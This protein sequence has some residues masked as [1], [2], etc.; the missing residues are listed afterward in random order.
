MVSATLAADGRTFTVRAPGLSGCQGGFSARIKVGDQEQELSSADGPPAASTKRV[1][2]ATPYGEAKLTATTIHFEQEQVD[3]LLR[4]GRVPGLPAVLAQVG[5][6]NTGQQPLDLLAVTPMALAVQVTGRPADWVI[7]GFKSSLQAVIGLDD[8]IKPLDVH[9]AG[10]LYNTEG[11]GFLFGPVGTPTSYVDARFT[12]DRGEGHVVFHM[13][14]DMSGACVEPGET[15]WGQQVALL[16]EKPNQAVAR[17]AEWVGKTH[18]ARTSKGA[19]AGWNSWNFL[20]NKDNG[21]EVLDVVAAVQGSVG[22]LRPEVIQID[23]VRQGGRA[24]LDAP[25]LP[26]VAQRVSETGARFGLR[27]AFERSPNPADPEA[28]TEISEIT[29]TVRRAVHSGFRYLKISCPPAAVRAVGEKRTA[30]EIYRDDWA[31]IRQAAGKDS[32]LL[33]CG[34]ANAPDRAV[35]GS[36]DACRVG[37]DAGRRGLR[38]AMLDV[39]RSDP[40]QGRWFAVDDDVYYMAA[41]IEGMREIVGGWPVARTWMSMVGLSCGAAITS[42]PWYWSEFQPYWRSVEVL[43][44]VAKEHTEVLG[45]GTG[46]EWPGLVGHVRREWGDSAVAM[47]WNSR[48]DDKAIRVRLDLADAGLD[49]ERHYAVWS[50]WDNQFLGVVKGSWTTPVLTKSASQHLCFT[51]LDRTPNKPVLIGSNLHIYCG[52]AEIKRVTSTHDSMR[53]ELTDAGA[54]EGDLWVYSRWQP[55]LMAATGCAIKGVASAGADVWRINLADRQLGVPQQVDLEILLPVTR[56]LWFWLLIALVVVS[57]VFAVW[58]LAASRRFQRDF[59][60]EHA[61]AS[62]RARIARDM[63]DEVGSHLARLSVLGEMVG[64]PPSDN[65]ADRLRIQ[66]IT[67]GV[68][69]A[70]GELEH[71]IWSV[72]PHNDTLGQLAHRICQYAEEFFS[73]TP[74]QCR[75]GTMPVIPA[76]AMGADARVAVFSAFKEALANILK[77]AAATTVDV[78]LWIKGRE[79]Q[80]RIVDNGRGFDPA[81]PAPPVGGNGLAN[82]RQRLTKLGGECRIDSAPGRGTTVIFCWPLDKAGGKG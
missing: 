14:A 60:R 81:Q 72:N 61:L 39:L 74:V 51:D 49:A 57:L 29:A 6:H 42:D 45:L 2:E 27:L 63:H 59:Q 32:Y 16:M 33:F 78:G 15:R 47:L 62:E 11:T 19:L 46:G 25:W 56:Y 20:R 55:V 18:R 69:E 24:V 36:V 67:R 1:T 77:H 53:I 68:R 70:A 22:H 17:W 71:I 26:A 73:D 13:S 48:T 38:T 76:M 34:E 9:E 31:A 58:R 52:A 50:F 12:P 75:F 41:E 82:M 23:D 44:P 65:A 30:F 5:I 37:S 64:D 21:K 8:V 54:R 66:K 35:V 79:F 10:G 40:L 7:T 4:L 28:P 43:T 3:L 80:V